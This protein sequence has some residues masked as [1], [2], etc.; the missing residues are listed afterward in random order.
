MKA[1]TSKCSS[2]NSDL[3]DKPHF[4]GYFHAYEK[5]KFLNRLYKF[6]NLMYVI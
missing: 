4:V 2:A 5:S 3:C 6:P 1:S